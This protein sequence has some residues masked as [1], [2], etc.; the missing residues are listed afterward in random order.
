MAWTCVPAERSHTTIEPSE[1]ATKAF[2]RPKSADMAVIVRAGFAAISRTSCP[3]ARFHR[4][5]APPESPERANSA[6]KSAT[7]LQTDTVCPHPPYPPPEQV[8]GPTS[9]PALRSQRITLVSQLAVRAL[10][11]MKS[12][13]T[14]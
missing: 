12:A 1:V 3:V 4:M 5:R 11:V 6:V 13:A 2:S 14:S 10:F 7:T 8:K 9:V